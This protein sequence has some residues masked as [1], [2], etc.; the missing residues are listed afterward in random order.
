[1]PAGRLR[2][3]ARGRCD[4]LSVDPRRADHVLGRRERA[5]DRI[6]DRRGGQRDFFSSSSSSISR[7]N[8]S[9]GWAPLSILPLTKNR[10]VP[11]T[12]ASWPSC[13]SASTRAFDARESTQASNVAESRPSSAARFFRS[14]VVRWPWS[15][16]RRSWNS[17]NFF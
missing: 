16:N 7:L 6:G 10:G 15:A 17:Q 1:G 9:Y 8:A 13:R 2:S 12:P 5:P 11:L 4:D 3:R 14:G